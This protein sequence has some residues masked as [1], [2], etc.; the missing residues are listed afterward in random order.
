MA[1]ST[2]TSTTGPADRSAKYENGAT[3]TFTGQVPQFDL[4]KAP[5]MDKGAVVAEPVAHTPSPSPSPTRA[6]EPRPAPQPVEPARGVE[7]LA[8]RGTT[9]IADEVVEKLVGIATKSVPGV[10]D[11]GGDLGRLFGSVK[12]RVGADV[13][14][15]RGIAVRLDGRTANIKI[16][17][18]IEYGHVIDGVTDRVRAAVIETVERML[19]VD[20]RAVDILVDDVHVP[21][22]VEAKGRRAR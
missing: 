18:V 4:A 7:A 17:L 14:P 1:E 6:A 19:S 3:P 10:H 15:G 9:S 12:E 20:V 2:G 11:L 13:E 21:A 8:N 16:T 5:L 22:E